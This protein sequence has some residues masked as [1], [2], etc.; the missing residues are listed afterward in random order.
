MDATVSIWK[1]SG[2]DSEQCQRVFEHHSLGVKSAKWSLDGRKILSGGYDGMTCY[3]DAETGQ[4]QE[5]RQPAPGAV[6]S[7]I[8]HFTTVCFHPL[9]PYSVLLG[10]D[11]GRIYSHDTREKASQ[12]PVTTYTKAF[13]DVHDLFFVGDNGQH[14]VS[15]ASVMQRGASNQTLLVWDWRSGTLLYDRLD[16]NMLAH[17]CLRAHP[18]RP[19][20]VAQCNGNYA[21]LYSSRAPYKCLKA[22]S[23]NGHRP[24]LRFSGGHV[25]EGYRIQCSFSRDGAFWASGDA[26]GCVAIYRT[27][28]KRDLLESFQLYGR[29]TACVCAEFQPSCA[30]V[31]L[32]M[33]HFGRQ[34]MLTGAWRSIVLPTSGNC[35]KAFSFMDETR[36]VFV[37]N[38]SRLVPIIWV[39]N[40]SS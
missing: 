38:F 24:P 40:M 22:S 32:A 36:L 35:W 3:V 33:V 9:E 26:N 16:D 37:Q 39:P 13:G 7:D 17:T 10:T 20:F 12:H 27:T 6:F 4:T 23:V 29:N 19:Y 8:E 25:V 21:T 31:F 5:L 34:E 18:S 11:K 28:D 1:L 14:F 15:S 2:D 30:L